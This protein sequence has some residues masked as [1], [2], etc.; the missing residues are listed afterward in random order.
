M[1]H[2]V[3]FPLV[4][5]TW[6]QGPGGWP[7]PPHLHQFV[8]RLIKTPAPRQISTGPTNQ[9]FMDGLVILLLSRL[10]TDKVTAY[11]SHSADHCLDECSE[12]NGNM[13]SSWFATKSYEQPIWRGQQEAWI[14]E[15]S[16]AWCYWLWNCL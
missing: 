10:G 14:I 6:K 16:F 1:G 4:G 7:Q 9:Y 3:Y 15:A 11:R 8:E 5:S 12:F 13:V 2:L